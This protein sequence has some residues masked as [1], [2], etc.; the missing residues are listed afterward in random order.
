MTNLKWM[1]FSL[2]FFL[3][4]S[5]SQEKVEKIMSAEYKDKIKNNYKNVKSYDYNPIYQVR[6]ENYNCPMELYVNDVLVVY[7]AGDGRSA[8]EQIVQVPQY[9]LKTGQQSIRVKIY[10]L[11]D[12]NRNFQKFVSRD[13][14]LKIRI[15]HQD[16]EREKTN[17]CKEVF[18]AELPKIEHDL[19]FIEL[20][21]E[22]T[23]TVPYELEGWSKGVDLSEEK[24]E[25]LEKEVNERLKE[26]AALYRN[27]DIGGL[28]KE[29][30]N[31]VRE[32]DQA[33]YFNTKESSASWESEIQEALNESKSIEVLSGK[34]KLM[35]NGKLVTVL[36]S[37]GAFKNKSII[38]SDVGDYYDFYPQ[39]FY[40]P[41]PGAKLEVIR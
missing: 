20:K 3:V 38:R 10:P 32:F 34:M 24:P 30:Y 22:F 35:A 41:S 27:K 36:I 26:V 13:A 4:S 1:S 40:R 29:H 37:D 31:R 17:E 8:G 12:K 25:E 21:R 16:Y 19:P 5:Y 15:T 9:I 18:K 14:E 33:Y 39:Y 6:Y 7:L 11:L 28:A 23:A 2:L